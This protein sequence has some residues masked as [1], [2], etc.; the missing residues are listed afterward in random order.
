MHPQQSTNYLFL[1]RNREK[2]RHIRRVIF[3]CEVASQ[4]PGAFSQAPV[5]F[6]ENRKKG[7]S[8]AKILKSG[9]CSP[10]GCNK[11]LGS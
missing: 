8:R 10:P 2:L 11:L 1:H 3:A 5:D 9:R 4:K 6:R 7:F